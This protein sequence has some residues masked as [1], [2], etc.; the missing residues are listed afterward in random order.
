[1]RTLLVSFVG[2]VAGWATL[3]S[4]ASNTDSPQQQMQKCAV[5]KAMAAK[6][7]LMKSMTWETHK[8]ANGMLSVASVPKDQKPDF[9]A[10]H[11]QMLQNIEQVKA[12]QQQGKAVELC[13][14][15]TA[16]SELMKSGAQKQDIDTTTGGICLVTSNDPAVVQ[17]IHAVADK[18]I[19][20]Q[21]EMQKVR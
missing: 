17:K 10:V 6:P 3:V 15:C 19:A 18:V 16:M 1:M 13:D 7:E 8:I 11:A 14:Y 5:C 2:I 12:D 20:E 21:A 9:D 4:A